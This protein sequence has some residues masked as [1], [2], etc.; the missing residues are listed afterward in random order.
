MSGALK[1]L[2]WRTN[3]V[4]RKVGSLE[5]ASVDSTDRSHETTM[6]QLVESSRAD[7]TLV[8]ASWKRV[9]EDPRPGSAIE[10]ESLITRRRHISPSALQIHECVRCQHAGRPVQELDLKWESAQLGPEVQPERD[11]L[12]STAWVE[13]LASMLAANPDFRL[14]TATFD[15]S[16]GFAVG[17]ERCA[18]KIYAGQIVACGRR[19][20]HAPTF[21][22]EAPEWVWVELMMADRDEFIRRTASGQLSARGE[23]FQYLRMTKAI[24]VML[25]AARA[26]WK[27]RV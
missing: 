19:T 27:A 22:L 8:G 14:A 2:L 5:R 13:A 11:D 7:L 12:G 25:D 6:Q 9:S 21:S 1:E 23:I 16:I 4:E 24:I 20:L 26:I 10:L 17:D 18:L 15:G 3:P